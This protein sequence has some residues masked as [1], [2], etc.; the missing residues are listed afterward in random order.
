MFPHVTSALKPLSVLLLVLLPSLSFALK[1]D[2]EAPMDLKAASWTGDMG[3][4][5][6]IFRGNVRITQGSLKIGADKGTV[7]YV[8]GQVERA[9]L[10]GTPAEVIQTQDSGSV[11]VARARKIDYNLQ[12]N[13]VV[14]TGGVSIDQGGNTTTGE[15]FEYSLDSGAISGNG[16]SG[17]VHMRLLPQKKPE[18]KSGTV[19]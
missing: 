16:G 8:K 11:V 9:E 13:V 17:E 2:R 4:G 5:V 10:E 12:R 14:L 19:P 1:S 3:T 6:Q 15:R 18:A 7:H